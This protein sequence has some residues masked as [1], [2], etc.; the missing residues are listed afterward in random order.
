MI[1]KVLVS[2]VAVFALTLGAN[3]YLLDVPTAKV[4][5]KD[6]RNDGIVMHAYAKGF[7]NP[8]HLVLDIWSIDGKSS[9]A[10]V[11]RVLFQ[12]SAPLKEYSFDKVTLAFRGNGRFTLD[13]GYFRK[14][15]SEFNA[16]QNPVY[17]IRTLPENVKHLDN[18]SAF[19]SWTGGLVAVLNK[20]IDDHNEFHNQWYLK[21]AVSEF[22][23]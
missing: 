8:H 10:D 15:G 5:A 11:D 18:T 17:L 3:W 2:A 16:G 19:Q 23:Q 4:L 7:V 1:G 14:L 12:V 20:Q 9:M 22:D 13:G 6:P 21:D